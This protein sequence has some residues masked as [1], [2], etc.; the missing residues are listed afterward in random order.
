[1]ACNSVMR[2]RRQ[3]GQIFCSVLWLEIKGIGLSV[4]LG[5]Q[6]ICVRMSDLFLI[7]VILIFRAVWN[8]ESS[9]WF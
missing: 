2:W 7:C 5:I 3:F 9:L 6:C 1:L 8:A 4:K